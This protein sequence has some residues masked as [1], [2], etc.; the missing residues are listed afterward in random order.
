VIH[1]SLG[2]T[3]RHRVIIQ[4]KHWG[5]TSIAVADIA[6]LKEQVKLWDKPRV[7]V[8]VV[9]TTGRFSADA[10]ATIEAH[11]ASDSGLKIEMWPESHLERLLAARPAL[12][13]DFGLR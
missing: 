12:I 3:T 11:N 8:L 4:C 1:D 5:D 6:T 10:V 2:G 7:D 13:A 9:A